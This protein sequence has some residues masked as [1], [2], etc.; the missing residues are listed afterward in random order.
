[1][2]N[3]L[4]ELLNRLKDTGSEDNL[5][6]GIN[7]YAPHL[8][9]VDNIKRGIL[10][11]LA[12]SPK[13][14][15]HVLLIGKPAS[16]KTELMREVH[17]SVS[18]SVFVT[19][20][21]TESGLSMNAT[22]GE[23]GAL[24]LANNSILCID[25]IDK[26]KKKELGIL[27]EALENQ[28]LT[29]N[30]AYFKGQHDT[31]FIC[32]AT[33]N[34]IK[35]L[36]QEVLSRFGLIFMFKDYDNSQLTRMIEFNLNNPKKNLFGQKL[37]GKIITDKWNKKACFDWTNIKD[38]KLIEQIKE[39]ITKTNSGDTLHKDIRLVRDIIR[40]SKGLAR[41]NNTLIVTKEEL[42]TVIE[43]VNE[44]LNLKTI[45]EDDKLSELIKIDKNELNKAMRWDSVLPILLKVYESGNYSEEYADTGV[46]DRL[47]Y[48]FYKIAN[49][50]NFSLEGYG[51]SNW[52]LFFYEKLLA[53]YPTR[54]QAIALIA[55]VAGINRELLLASL[56][57][58]NQNFDFDKY[59]DDVED[60]IIQL[61]QQYGQVVTQIER[62]ES[63]FKV[64]TDKGK[65]FNVLD[66]NELE[67][68]LKQ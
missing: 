57:E 31:N 9:E 7:L 40:L 35:K 68:H 45:L 13:E 42:K 48:Y 55:D 20:R 37:L 30:S 62:T 67:E 63:G 52:F 32:L 4:I 6:K 2:S 26:F 61:G 12:T 18:G 60:R 44:S 16:G 1:M 14:P 33:C 8:L 64:H 58:D 21:S 34:N 24:L 36:P 49:K 53:E 46:K 28:R 65:L 51:S 15:V 23:S 3:K 29:V 27:L 54:E 10:I 38:N 47:R 50:I 5:K 43:L 25:E 17:N 66:E 11:A 19:P 39:I 41:W 22:T 56:K 59:L